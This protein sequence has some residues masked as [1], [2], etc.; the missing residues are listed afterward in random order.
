MSENLAQFATRIR[1]LADGELVR[2]LRPVIVANALEAERIARQ[3]VGTVLH[4]RTGRLRGS[5]Q[6]RARI[7]EGSAH[8]DLVLAA[9]GG[10]GGRPVR[11]AAIHEKGGI[12]RAK[13]GGLLRIPMPGMLT[14]AGV[15]RNPGS[16]RGDARFSFRRGTDGRMWLASAKDGTPAYRLVPQVTIPARPYLR[17]SLEEVRPKVARDLTAA[18]KRLIGGANG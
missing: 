2:Q 17:P 6:G 3:R 13:A 11:Y 15:D 4:V 5:I 12:V 1:R 16:L 10:R 14:G 7:T 8:L 9:G 18:M